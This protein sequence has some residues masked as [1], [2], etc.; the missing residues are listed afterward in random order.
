M[1]QAESKYMG[2]FPIKGP[3]GVVGALVVE[4]ST[5]E[6]I[7]QA[8]RKQIE[9]LLVEGGS[10]IS[11][12]LAYRHLPFAPLLRLAAAAR[13]GLYRMSRLRRLVWIAAAVLVVMLPFVLTKQV[14]VVGTAELVPVAARTVYVQHEGVVETVLAAEKQV[15]AAGELLGRLDTRRLDSD[16]DGVQS[17]ISGTQIELDREVSQRGESSLA[18]QLRSTKRQLVAHLET[19][20]AEREQCEIRS[21]VA[22]MVITPD[23]ALRQLLGRPVEAGEALLEVVPT[24]TD[25]ELIVE[26]PEDEAGDLLRAYDDLDEGETLAALV[27]LNVAPELKLPARVLSISPRAHVMET[28]PRTYRNV[29]RV[30]VSE[31]E[32]LGEGIEPRQGMEGM[33][34]IEC[35][36]RHLFYVVTHEFADFVRISM[37]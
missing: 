19:L 25:W 34:A 32:G 26:V 30:Q 11:N 2:V 5:E 35:G 15:V 37:F 24:D 3:D 28:G 7:E 18:K 8:E 9:A 21:P 23:S 17:Q 4:K 14:K 31:P 22:G 13:D 29:I 1:L 33:A 6:P 20:Q 12:S 27:I 10:A 16:I 36:R